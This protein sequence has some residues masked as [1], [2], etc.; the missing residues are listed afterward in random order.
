[1]SIHELREQPH[2]SYSAL[3]CYLTCPMKYKFRYVDNA[4]VERT[5]SALP[6]GRAFH[7]VLSERALK[8]PDF[9]L[10]DAQENFEFY[11]KGETDVSEN[12]HYK[13][14]ETFDS[15]LNTGFDMLTAVLENWQ[16]DFA[17]KSVAESFSVTVPGL[18]CPLIGEFD[19]VVSDGSETTIVDWKTASSK[20]A[21][22]K[23][24]RDLQA[25]AFCYAYKQVH[26]KVPVF[27]FDVITKAK[28]PSV[29]SHYTLRT[30][31]ELDR[32][33]FTAGRIEKAVN[34]E[35]FYPNENN[36][37]CAECSYA[38]RCKKAIWKGD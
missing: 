26:G 14:N 35:L 18:L 33:E 13:A 27:R 20:W 8:G 10:E 19:C 24:G 32:F 12:L 38:D 6:F 29:N 21:S 36:I 7:A 9:K 23:A 28:Q 5:S 31:D 11:F 16:D 37:N 34:A 25:S 17:V 22:G 3:Q 2:W 1:M 4:P 15:L 30:Q